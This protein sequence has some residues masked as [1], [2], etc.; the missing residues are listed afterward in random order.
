MFIATDSLTSFFFLGQATVT[1]SPDS[2][3]FKS[4]IA[5]MKFSLYSLTITITVLEPQPPLDLLPHFCCTDSMA[6]SVTV[7]LLD[8]VNV[9]LMALASLASPSPMSC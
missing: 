8:H 2:S 1:T 6:E 9:I 4:K 7:I 3:R 5:K